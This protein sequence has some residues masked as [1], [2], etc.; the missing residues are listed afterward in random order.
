MAVAGNAAA[1]EIVRLRSVN[2][3]I[4]V[5]ISELR[6]RQILN[7]ETIGNL[8]HVAMWEA[9]PGAPLE[10]AEPAPDVVPGPETEGEV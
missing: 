8:A 2:Q 3:D 9:D 10:P 4:D 5:Q 6:D 7:A 1:H